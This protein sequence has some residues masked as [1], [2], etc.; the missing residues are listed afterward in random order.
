MLDIKIKTKIMK[1]TMLLLLVLIGTYQTFAQGY[2]K[3][4]VYTNG[5][6]EGC[7]REFTICLEKCWSPSGNCKTGNDIICNTDCK[8][9]ANGETGSKMLAVN[10]DPLAEP[11]V[12]CS[13]KVTITMDCGYFEFNQKPVGIDP[14]WGIPGKPS[15]TQTFYCGGCCYKFTFSHLSQNQATG[16]FWPVFDISSCP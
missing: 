1:K 12:I 8:S 2:D 15:A 6:A 7:K 5:L 11:D 16:E 13:N 14:G 4:E 3:A 10:Y 9:F